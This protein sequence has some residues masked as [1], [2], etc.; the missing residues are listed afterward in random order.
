MSLRLHSLWLLALLGCDPVIQHLGVL[1]ESHLE[2]SGKSGAVNNSGGFV[3]TVKERSGGTV[4]IM[5]TGGVVTAGGTTGGTTSSSTDT[6]P[7]G[8]ASVDV[9]PM[10][11]CG[12]VQSE[13]AHAQLVL[14][15]DTS[16][17]ISFN[18]TNPIAEALA[19]YARDPR[20]AGTELALF[21][22]RN[23]NCGTGVYTAA[24]VGLSMLPDQSAAIESGVPP[25]QVNLL[26]QPEEA[27]AAAIRF[28]DPLISAMDDNAAA[29]G[30]L[31]D[32]FPFGF[33]ANST[34][35]AL[36]TTISDAY[37]ATQSVQTYVMPLVAGGFSS[38]IW[39]TGATPNDLAAAGGTGQA[40]NANI[41]GGT[42][43]G[44]AINNAMQEVRAS[45]QP[46]RIRIVSGTGPGDLR[47]GLA[48]GNEIPPVPNEAGCAGGHGYYFDSANN[49][50]LG[51]TLCP[52][53]CSL[54]KSSGINALE[55]G[56]HCP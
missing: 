56:S 40:H 18:T 43:P 51:A 20:S 54:V 3:I 50:L 42:N 21:V 26:T 7:T 9:P 33:C 15:V 31:T 10:Y 22:L 55:L 49:W 35:D 11:N 2:N 1:P 28:A 30:L 46:C 5:N 29:V 34:S 6:N 4:A 16:F 44:E 37:Q 47:I 24:D 14:V 27:V 13:L 12:L 19:T 48:G 45:L 32:G 52:E 39:G 17:S 41:S 36:L 38:A 53:S 23:T 8:G 25:V